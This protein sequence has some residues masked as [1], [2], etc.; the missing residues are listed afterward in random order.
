MYYVKD[1][2]KKRL[3]LY[4]DEMPAEEI[5]S[6]L[7]NE[8]WHWNKSKRCWYTFLSQANIEAAVALGAKPTNPAVRSAETRISHNLTKVHATT[9]ALTKFYTASTSWESIRLVPCSTEE[10]KNCG[11]SETTVFQYFMINYSLYKYAAESPACLALVS[12]QWYILVDFCKKNNLIHA[13]YD[14]SIDPA[15]FVDLAENSYETFRLGVERFL[16]ETDPA[17]QF[18]KCVYGIDV[19]DFEWWKTYWD[20][21]MCRLGHR[22]TATSDFL[23]LGRNELL[24]L[25]DN[26]CMDAKTHRGIFSQESDAEFWGQIIFWELEAYRGQTPA[27]DNTLYI[28]K[29]RIICQ[30]RHHKI[31]QATAI[32]SGVAGTDLLLNVNYCAECRKFFMSYATYQHYR[33]R[34]GII[35]GD[36]KM[37]KREDFN[38]CEDGLAEE[39]K[40]HLCG[41]SVS[42]KDGLSEAQRQSIISFVIS[43][44]IMKKEEVVSHLSWLIDTHRFR[45]IMAS[46]VQ[47]WDADLAYTL[48]YDLD[49]QPKSIIG[50]I[51]KYHPNQFKIDG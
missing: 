15:H 17:V 44:G 39:S 36:L 14:E 9:P 25:M 48:Q 4:F 43:R 20:P 38:G 10:L 13:T 46:A 50:S 12:V 21:T 2:Y 3:D 34:Y 7:K 30:T 35:L 8:G 24:S 23:P 33:N 32:L 11:L 5:L 45:D 18:I 19:I 29:S 40:L 47:K 26:I 31:I 37:L 27:E 1:I 42:G 22:A 28:H 49:R 51:R 16:T 41:Y 6:F